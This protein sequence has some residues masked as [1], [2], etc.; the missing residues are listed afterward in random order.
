MTEQPNAEMTRRVV[1]RGA[2]VAGVTMPLLVACGSDDPEPSA[3]P[4]ESAPAEAG[5]SLASTADVPVGGGVVLK[6][7]KI[8]VTQPTE[9]DFKAFTAVCTHKQCVVAEVA[10]GTIK[11]GCHGS[12]YSAE[13]GSVTGGPAPAPLE[14]IAITVEGD[15]ITQS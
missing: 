3:E 8:V 12:M 1:L 2:T 10:D 11:C 6:D 4:E 9:G 7:E 5:A 15:Q 14:E 13:D